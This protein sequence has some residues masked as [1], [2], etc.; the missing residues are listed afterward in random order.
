MS[1]KPFFI[2]G[3]NAKVKVN[4]KTLAFCTNLSYSVQVNNQVPKVLGMYEGTSIEPLGYLVTGSFTVIRYVKNMNK[5]KAMSGAN[6]NGNGIGG[7]TSKKG[8]ERLI[9]GRAHENL[10][11]GTFQNGTYFDIEVYQKIVLPEDDSKE[12][13]GVAKIR[14]CRITRADFNISK[15]S[16]ATQTFSFVALY[17]DEDSFVADFSGIGQQFD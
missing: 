3:A 8:I 9:D 11:P 17:A 12:N 15:R 7:W 4:N 5:I 14:N 6:N 13:L 1:F 10:N 2:T 16:A